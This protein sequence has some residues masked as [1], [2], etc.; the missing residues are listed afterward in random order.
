MGAYPAGG[1]AT[2]F[3]PQAS[4]AHIWQDPGAFGYSEIHEAVGVLTLPRRYNHPFNMSQPP[5]SSSMAQNIRTTPPN[6]SDNFKVVFEAALEV[7]NKKTKQSLQDHPLLTQ[8]ESCD[9]PT[10]ILDLLRG[11]VNPNANEGLRKWLNPTIHVLHAFS[12]T[13]GEGV[14]LVNIN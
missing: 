10:A 3:V 6:D 13:I 2:R 4:I 7:Y 11:Q 14:G 9:S 1:S 12:G 8:L 5:A